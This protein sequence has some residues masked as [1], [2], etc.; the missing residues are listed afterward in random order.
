MV[1][2]LLYGQGEAC[3]AV[4]VLD[5]FD[6]VID[7]SKY[8]QKVAKLEKEVKTFH[9]FTFKSLILLL[10]WRRHDI[11]HN[12]KEHNDMLHNG[13]QHNSKKITL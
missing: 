5:R 13:T 8:L 10:F 7:V 9:F 12:V 6:F 11:Y 1:L 2:F 3:A 4:L